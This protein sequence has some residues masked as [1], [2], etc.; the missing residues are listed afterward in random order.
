MLNVVPP[1]CLPCSSRIRKTVDRIRKCFRPSRSRLMERCV[2][3]VC[4]SGGNAERCVPGW[5]DLRRAWVPER[6][7][8]CFRGGRRSGG[9]WLATPLPRRSWPERCVSG[10]SGGWCLA[11]VSARPPTWCCCAC[12]RRS[13]GPCSTIPLPRRSWLERCVPGVCCNG[14]TC[15]HCWHHRL[16]GCVPRPQPPQRGQCSRSTSSSAVT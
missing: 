5:C 11:R 16:E 15:D 7:P 1:S 2:P 14:G 4:C 9:P 8:I 13:G 6:R 10:R 3:L 12:G